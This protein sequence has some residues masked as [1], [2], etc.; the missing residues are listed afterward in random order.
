[1]PKLNLLTL[2]FFNILLSI[3]QTSYIPGFYKKSQNERLA[4][5]KTF[6]LLTDNEI[7]LLKNCNALSPK[8]AKVMVENMI[9]SIQI[10]V[11]IATNFC[12][13]GKDY[14]I[15]MATEEL[16]VIAAAS[17][18]AKLTRVTGGFKTT[19][20]QQIMIGQIQITDIKDIKKFK[21]ALNENKTLILQKANKNHP[22]LIAHG[23]GARDLKLRI[24][25]NNEH[26]FYLIHLL[27]DAQDAMGSNLV[28]EM[29][30]TIAPFI[31]QSCHCKTELKIVSNLAVYRIVIAQATWKKELI[32]KQTVEKIVK[33]NQLAGCDL[34]R[35][36]THN[37]G[38][39]NGIDAVATATGNDWRAIEAGAHAY[40]AYNHPYQPLTK[41]YKNKNGDLVG[42]LKLPL[43]VGIIGGSTQIN[44][45]AKICLK[46]LQVKTA[47]ELAQIMAAVGLAQNFAA[48]RAL[49][50]EGIQ[51]G[52]IK[53]HQKKFIK[54]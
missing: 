13:N 52:Y 36:T 31:E 7:A 29:V 4:Y 54:F 6:S 53:L 14:L 5:L 51:H 3:N 24:I 12:I 11:G 17:C 23:G 37:K 49:T 33:A 44:P 35:C 10:P 19:A 34:F 9:T 22:H 46:I 28:N 32:G 18:G 26:V 27:V 16:S 43:A 20:S 21:K 15:P 50:N 40:A 1:M 41:Y 48:L 42:E 30:E 2:T 47:C 25:N 45:T 38:I 8:T 39:I